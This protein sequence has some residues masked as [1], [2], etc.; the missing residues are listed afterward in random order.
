LQ[1]NDENRIECVDF[2]EVTVRNKLV[3]FIAHGV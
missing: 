1:S 3:L 2:D